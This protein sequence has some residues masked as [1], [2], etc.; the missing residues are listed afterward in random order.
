MF[1]GFCFSWL[2]CHFFP[3]FILLL[4]FHVTHI[5]G[6]LGLCVVA[7]ELEWLDEMGDFSLALSCFQSFRLLSIASFTFACRSMTCCS[8]SDG[9]GLFYSTTEYHTLFLSIIIQYQHWSHHWS[10]H[11]NCPFF[12]LAIFW[13]QD[14]EHVDKHQTKCL[15]CHLLPHLLKGVDLGVKWSKNWSYQY[16]LLPE[17]NVVAELW[18]CLEILCW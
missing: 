5:L 2:W 3:C 15:P 11:N 18:D 14:L 7:D 13:I 6:I 1:H 16:L 8:S 10:F 17:H 12:W 4:L 9:K